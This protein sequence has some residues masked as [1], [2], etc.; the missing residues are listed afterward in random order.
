MDSLLD[1]NLLSRSCVARRTNKIPKN[2]GFHYKEE[3][4]IDIVEYHVDACNMFSEQLKE[5]EF[6]SN[7]SVSFPREEKLLIISSHDECIFK[8]YALTKKAWVAP[9]RECVLVPKDK[10]QG[11]KISAFQS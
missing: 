6:G 9:N 3:S 1:P 5:K 2:S 10:R 4:E 11:I 7:L 8:Q